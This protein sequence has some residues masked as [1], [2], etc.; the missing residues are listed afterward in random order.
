MCKD[1]LE[2]FSFQENH[3]CYYFIKNVVQQ[4]KQSNTEITNGLCWK[5][6]K[7]ISVSTQQ[8]NSFD[9]FSLAARSPA[10][11]STINIF[12]SSVYRIQNRHASWSWFLVMHIVFDSLRSSLDL[13]KLSVKY[14]NVC[15]FA[16]QGWYD[17]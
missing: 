4:Q 1:D 13:R 11:F 16:N 14:K 10:A 7:F 5:S 17:Q 3:W 12:G 9:I 15:L 2:Q 8:L 6:F